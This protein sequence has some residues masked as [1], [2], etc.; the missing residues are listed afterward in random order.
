MDLSTWPGTRTRDLRRLT[1]GTAQ[2]GRPYG[3]AKRDGQPN[4]TGIAAILA[5]GVGVG[6]RRPL[7]GTTGK[8]GYDNQVSIEVE[9]SGS[10]QHRAT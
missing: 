6:K 4:A 1:L 2:W 9:M 7:F 10:G 5:R 8:Y 3:I